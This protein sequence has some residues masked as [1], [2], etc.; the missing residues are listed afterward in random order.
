[1]KDLDSQLR[2]DA[3]DMVTLIEPAEDLLERSLARSQLATPDKA[4]S[5]HKIGPLW[6]AAI[7]ATLAAAVFLSLSS[8][9]VEQ[10]SPFQLP[11]SPR[12]ADIPDLDA[13]LSQELELVQKDLENI[14]QEIQSDLD[15]WL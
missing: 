9:Q 3:A 15:Y 6:W 12:L 1:M 13:G 2:R 5:D 4:L 10:Q 7:P 8:P 14:R 11:D